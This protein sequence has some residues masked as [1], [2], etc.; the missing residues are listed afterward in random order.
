MRIAAHCFQEVTDRLRKELGIAYLCSLV[1]HLHY[2]ELDSIV[3]ALEDESE[4]TL[5]LITATKAQLEVRNRRPDTEGQARVQLE[6]SG[7]R[8]RVK[9]IVQVLVEPD[10]LEWMEDDE[11]LTD[12]QYISRALNEIEERFKR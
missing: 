11:S 9:S 7:W 10:Q 2:P 8:S 3:E 6:D 4:G 12:T 1:P 5:D